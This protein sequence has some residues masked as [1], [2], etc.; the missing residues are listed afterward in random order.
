M[1]ELEIITDRSSDFMS[2]PLASASTVSLSET[3]EAFFLTL[4]Q[5]SF[6]KH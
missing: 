6:L 5:Y 1:I 4:L 2:P 3:V